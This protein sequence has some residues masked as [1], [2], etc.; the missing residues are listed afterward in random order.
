MA[1]GAVTADGRARVLADGNELPLLGLGFWQVPDGPECDNA[2]HWALELGYRHIDTAQRYGNE[3]SV[4]RALRDSGVPREEVFITTKFD[5]AREDAEV[6]AQ[7]SLERLGV[8]HLDLYIIH[9]PQG[10]PTRAW[11]GMERAHQRGFARS[12]GVSN[13]SVSELDELMSVAEAPPVVNQVEF[14]PFKYRRKLLE[15]CQER[16]VTL[17]AYSPLGTGAHLSDERVRQVAERVGR[18][19]AQVLLRWCVQRNLPV[20]T[21]STHRDRIE[22]NAQILDFALPDEEMAALDALDET[23]GTERAVERSWRSRARSMMKS[24]K[25]L[26]RVG[27]LSGTVVG[28]GFGFQVGRFVATQRYLF[29]G[30]F[31]VDWVG[32]N[33]F[34]R[35]YARSRGLA[36]QKKFAFHH[37]NRDL[38]VPGFADSVQAGPVPGTDHSG[39]FVMLADSPELRASG[40][41]TMGAADAQGRP[42]SYDALVVELTEAP[43]PERIRELDLPPDFR[44][45]AYGG[46]KVVVW[47]PIAGNMTRTSAGCDEFRATAGRV[48]AALEGSANTRA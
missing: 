6:E 46:N 9:W 13:Y 8:E 48:I 1:A 23:G 38:P 33:A 21:K 5:S 11:P 44:V 10:E 28:G 30:T 39:L 41:H 31:S 40:R 17:E 2:V 22:E 36:R 12:I 37:E 19:P 3:G 35:E 34:N 20:I 27:L 15:A 16:Q 7:R 14:S 47:R 25:S 32:I 18:T 45:D 24:V 26:P 4:G 43:T 42:L 29:D